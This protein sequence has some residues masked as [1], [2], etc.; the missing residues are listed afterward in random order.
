MNLRASVDSHFF[1]PIV[2]N[3]ETVKT[4]N[5]HS[6]R[7]YPTGEAN[8][9]LY[10]LAGGGDGCPVGSGDGGVEGAV[11]RVLARDV[12]RNRSRIDRHA[13]MIP[14]LRHVLRRRSTGPAPP[15]PSRHHELLQLV[16]RESRGHHCPIP[17]LTPEHSGSR[18]FFSPV[19]K[20]SNPLESGKDL[21]LHR[22]SPSHLNGIGTLGSIHRWTDAHCAYAHSFLA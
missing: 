21:G 11:A 16:H 1:R 7:L 5:H 13:S 8:Y 20:G 10:P 4:P 17:R 12:P 14:G 15:P 18:A 6:G 22:P 9:L 3:R 19:R 2:D